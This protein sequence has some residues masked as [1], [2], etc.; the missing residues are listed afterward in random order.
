VRLVD[1]KVVLLDDSMV[2][3]MELQMAEMKG[4]YQ[5]AWLVSWKVDR[6]GS[7][8]AVVWVVRMTERMVTRKVVPWVVM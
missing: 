7:I 1:E 4:F 6:M 8:A 5:V 3:Q 2:G